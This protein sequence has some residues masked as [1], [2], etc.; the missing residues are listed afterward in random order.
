[1][2]LVFIFSERQA[3]PTFESQYRKG[4]PQVQG[5]QKDYVYCWGALTKMWS[6]MNSYTLSLNQNKA[7][8]KLNLTC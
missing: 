4:C 3:L 8:I 7:S 6:S 1:M 5:E 2:H